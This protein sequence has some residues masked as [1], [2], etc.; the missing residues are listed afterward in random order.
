MPTGIIRN[1]DS[2]VLRWVIFPVVIPAITVFWGWLWPNGAFRTLAKSARD[3]LAAVL[4]CGPPPLSEHPKGLFLNGSEQGEY[5]IEALDS[6]KRGIVWRGSV[7]FAKLVEGE[8]LLEK[9]K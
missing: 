1:S 7:R 2:W 6:V 9:W 4:A 8:T 5:N 3:V